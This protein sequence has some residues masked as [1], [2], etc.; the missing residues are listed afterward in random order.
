MNPTLRYLNLT[1]NED[2]S[3][4]QI[5]RVAFQLRKSGC[6]THVFF[7]PREAEMRKDR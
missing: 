5:Q 4:I 7:M 6:N 3:I 2:P 1:F